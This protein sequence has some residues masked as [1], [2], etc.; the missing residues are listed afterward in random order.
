[1]CKEVGSDEKKTL[2]PGNKDEETVKKIIA[3]ESEVF[4]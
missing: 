3:G 2:A 4:K 1:L